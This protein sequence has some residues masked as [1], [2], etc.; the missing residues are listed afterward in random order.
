EWQS[1]CEARVEPSA[2]AIVFTNLLRNALQAAPQ[3]HVRI[4][5]SAHEVRIIDDGD[6]LPTEWPARSG[7]RGR[8]LGLL[9]A[10]TLAER[11]GW[12]VRLEPAQPRGTTALLVLPANVPSAHKNGAL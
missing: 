5:A 7:S 2:F 6:G 9:I 4:E 8:G 1:P 10:R 12:Q 3:G 11:H